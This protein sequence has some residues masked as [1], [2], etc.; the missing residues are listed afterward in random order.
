M[1]SVPILK[2]GY[3]H[4]YNRGIKK[5]IIFHD[6]PDYVRFMFLM[7]FFQ[8]PVSIPQ[9][10][11]YIKNYL[12]TNDYKISEAL[13]SEILQDRVVEL[14]N[15]CIMPNHFHA[16]VHSLKDG[17]V[18]E[19]MHKVCN[20]YAKYYNLKYK[21]TGH[22]FQGSYKVKQYF[23]E[24]DLVYLSAYIHRNPQELEKWK[25]RAIEYPWSSYQDYLQS[26]WADLLIPDEILNRF[27][28]N[29]E[30]YNYVEKSGAKE[31]F[32]FSS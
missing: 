10:N 21:N 13:L 30:Y 12:L 23:D 16:T 20:S 24:N 15:F 5:Q 28:S 11:R 22:V 32:F 18:G 8:S 29:D 17:S 3:Y 1:R 31:I 4:I 9:C 7:L 26:R 27:Q 2:G 19:Y 6:R 14:M 25:N